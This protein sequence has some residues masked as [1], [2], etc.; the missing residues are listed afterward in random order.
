MNRHT[1]QSPLI[2]DVHSKNTLE[3]EHFSSMSIERL[4]TTTLEKIPNIKMV[5][6]R[7]QEP[8]L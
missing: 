3:S 8:H 6:V 7:S 4:Q 5:K 2:P 1:S